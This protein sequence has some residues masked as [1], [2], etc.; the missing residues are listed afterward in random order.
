[1]ANHTSWDNPLVAQHPDWYLR[2]WKGDFTP[3]PWWDWTDIINLDYR[4]PALRRYMTQAMVWWVREA[5]IDGYRCDVAGFVPV[6]FWENV[7][8]ELDAV[9]PVFMLAEWES[10][11]LHA[12]AFDMTYAWTWYDAVHGIARGTAE[13]GRA[14]V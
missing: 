13:I 7:R 1:M 2:D 4:S 5:G 9:K 14:H 8:R 12:A 6:D 10:R 11:D 3:T